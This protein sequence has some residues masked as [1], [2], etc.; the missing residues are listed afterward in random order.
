MSW[1][2]SEDD[3]AYSGPLSTNAETHSFTMAFAFGFHSGLS[4]R[5]WVRVL[6]L[7]VVSAN[8]HRRGEIIAESPHAAMGYICGYVCGFVFGSIVENRL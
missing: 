1:A 8:Q 6:F 4:G 7:V 3:L 2:D 5:E